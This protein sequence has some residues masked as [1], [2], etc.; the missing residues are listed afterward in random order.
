MIAGC[1]GERLGEVVDRLV[2]DEAAR[3]GIRL[4]RPDWRMIWPD[5]QEEVLMGD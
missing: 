3:L 4:T 1:I 5:R 2:A